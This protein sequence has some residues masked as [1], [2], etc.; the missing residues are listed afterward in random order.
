MIPINK[1]KE[2]ASLVAYRQQ[3][4]AKYDGP[5]FTAVKDDI[6]TAL[7]EEQGFLCAYCMQRI[8]NDQFKTKIEHWHSQKN[9]P[10]E[11][12][13]YKN[14]LAVCLGKTQRCSHCDETKGD[15]DIAFNPSD[16]SHF[17]QMNIKY[18]ANGEIS[19]GDTQFDADINHVL[20]LNC[21]KSGNL[22]SSRMIQNRKATWGSVQEVLNQK[23]GL[24]TKAEIQEFIRQWESVDAMDQKKPYCGVALF[25]LNKKLAQCP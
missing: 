23:K 10:N 8:H 2:P 22:N 14:M 24:R 15:K 3:V 18:S 1:K 9:H 16:P 19:S 4:G 7:L 11:Q 6:R 25:Y 17:Q 13:N 12:L 20:G 5:N 21:V